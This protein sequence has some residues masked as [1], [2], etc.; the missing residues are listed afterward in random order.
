MHY[1]SISFLIC[2]GSGN[3]KF[4]NNSPTG[5][6]FLSKIKHLFQTR[7]K[8][9]STP[10]FGVFQ[11]LKAISTYM[12][13]WWE[14]YLFICWYLKLTLLMKTKDIN[15]KAWLCQAQVRNISHVCSQAEKWTKEQ[16]RQRILKLAGSS[17]CVSARLFLS[18]FRFGTKKITYCITKMMLT[19]L[20]CHLC[21]LSITF[22][23]FLR[24]AP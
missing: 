13:S 22:L 5:S 11:N 10:D 20:C 7:E 12:S 23:S 21:L 18:C 17:S 15:H 3:A 16:E 4:C 14:F 8:F 24:E 2:C 19:P 6:L 1:K 9:S